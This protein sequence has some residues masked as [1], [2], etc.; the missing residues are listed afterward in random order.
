MTRL[1]FFKVKKEDIGHFFQKLMDGDEVMEIYKDKNNN[2]KH[3]VR[4]R[5][6]RIYFGNN[7]SIRVT[8]D[9]KTNDYYFSLEYW[10]ADD[11]IMFNSNKPTHS[12]QKQNRFV[13]EMN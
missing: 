10:S 1:E 13:V 6:N 3:K 4:V 11:R 5:D 2:D 9:E 7:Y 8:K 12:G